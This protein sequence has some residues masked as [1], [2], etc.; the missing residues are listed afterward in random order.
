M[1]D[2]FSKLF[3]SADGP[4]QVSGE[5]RLPPGKG[6]V[7]GAELFSKVFFDQSVTEAVLPRPGIPLALVSDTGEA[8]PDPQLPAPEAVDDVEAV[9]STDPVI[10]AT[11]PP[12]GTP[13][14]Q[15]A[16]QALPAAG[17]PVVAAAAAPVVATET[18]REV[19]QSG[20]TAESL[21]TA[22]R[23]AQP[24]WYSLVGQGDA[25]ARQA[26]ASER[27]NPMLQL[28]DGDADPQPL[29][30]ANATAAVASAVAQPAGST[31]GVANTTLPPVPTS[32]PV[33][34]QP[35]QP[36]WDR[37]VGQRLMWMINNQEQSASIRLNPPELGPL[38]AKIQIQNDTVQV[39]FTS[40]HAPVRDA[41]EAALPRL[42]EMFAEQGLNLGQADV[43]AEQHARSEHPTD[44]S[45]GGGSRSAEPNQPD[46]D[47][48]A[49]PQL[50]GN[51]LVDTFA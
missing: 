14:P 21:D 9:E 32:T 47:H 25:E 11:L 41:L 31:V 19:I 12:Q 33:E 28:A 15:P 3:S 50:V 17:A 24:K 27:T 37:A 6:P 42:R 36:G 16:E 8:L 13:L 44:D 29:Q 43:S 51:A 48:N 34:Q 20:V 38:E 35:G 26:A 7:E 2:I 22:V 30:F 1:T 5:T 39:H 23:T 45:R 49:G 4:L 40:H 10:G 46:S 18:S